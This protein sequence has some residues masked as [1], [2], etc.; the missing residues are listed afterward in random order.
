MATAED[1]GQHGQSWN[2]LHHG[3]GDREPGKMTVR[4]ESENE[5][6]QHAHQTED[7]K[8]PVSVEAIKTESKRKETA[9]DANKIDWDGD[10]DPQNPRNWSVW[11]RGVVIGTVMAIVFTTSLATSAIA[12]A[13]AQLL[14]EFHSDNELAATLVVTIELM[15]T[16]VA[17]L[18]LAPLSEIYGRNLIYH[19]SNVTFCLF[20]MGCALAPTLGALVVLRFFQG[21]SASGFI[22]N[23][24]GII[25]DLV[26]THRRGTVMS[27]FSLGF[28]FGPVLGPIIGSY[29]TAAAGWRWIFWL[30]LIMVSKL[31][32]RTDAGD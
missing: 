20:T 31:I 24:G 25:A 8:S 3:L 26:P 2:A 19:I 27:L 21:C 7:A 5:H 16:A 22:N 12:P 13:I 32:S 6:V 23:V 28:L 1:T 10:D 9:R 14:D 15:G 30:L 11:S 17:P 18:L 29:S 4:I